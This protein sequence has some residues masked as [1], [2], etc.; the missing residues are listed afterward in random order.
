MKKFSLL[1]LLAVF[2][3][4]FA[5]KDTLRIENIQEVVVK[6]DATLKLHQK[7]GKYEVFVAGTNFQNMPNTWEG[8][9][10]VPMLRAMDG[11]G[12]K[13]NNKAAII[14]INGIQT[15][16]TGTDLENY[17]KS[18]DPKTIK[19]LRLSLIPM[20]PTEQRCKLL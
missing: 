8:L 20:H 13:V 14:L 4:A 16:M 19:K 3:T 1:I 7:N 2:K 5:Q 15:Q 9:K 6:S 18:L 12:L 11:T 17:L 10:Q